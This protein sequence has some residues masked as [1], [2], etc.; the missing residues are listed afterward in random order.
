MVTAKTFDSSGSMGSQ[1]RC[2]AML[3]N[4]AKDNK[5]IA[6]RV[7]GERGGALDAV[8]VKAGRLYL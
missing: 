8:C 2:K 7:V 5:K 3:Q 4:V 1:I 6:R